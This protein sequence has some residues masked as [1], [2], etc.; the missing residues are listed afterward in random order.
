ML[1]LPWAALLLGGCT[2]TLPLGGTGLG[3]GAPVGDGVIEGGASGGLMPE[4]SGTIADVGVNPIPPTDSL[5]TTAGGFDLLG[6]TFGVTESVDVGIN[7]SRG[8][9]SMVRLAGSDWWSMSISPAVYRYSKANSAND[10]KGVWNLNLTGLVSAHAR[11]E[12]PFQASVYLA[13]AL[14]RFSASIEIPSGLAHRSAVAP[15]VLAGIRL[16]LPPCIGLCGPRRSR[17]IAFGAEA[18]GAW[19]RQRSS[20]L[21]LVRTARLYVTI[22]GRLRGR[23]GSG[24]PLGPG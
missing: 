18:Q 15:S 22:G 14:N 13:G 3:R 7:F 1:A 20:R 21:D 2:Y 4:L 11:P 16:G 19:I 9:H 10:G 6:V 12:S 5:T 23:G 17:Y 24:G 8:L